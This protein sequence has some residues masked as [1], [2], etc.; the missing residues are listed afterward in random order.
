MPQKNLWKLHVVVLRNLSTGYFLNVRGNSKH[1]PR[2]SVKAKDATGMSKPL[3]SKLNDPDL[4][5]SSTEK[6]FVVHHI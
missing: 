2:L 6:L 3:F 4:F 5:Y 1:L